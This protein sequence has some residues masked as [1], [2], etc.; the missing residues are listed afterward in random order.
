[1]TSKL[2]NTM[3]ENGGWDNFE[4]IPIE[5]YLCDTPLQ[6]RMREQFWINNIEEKN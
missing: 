3:R 4:M 5:E 6:A 2:Y 1:M